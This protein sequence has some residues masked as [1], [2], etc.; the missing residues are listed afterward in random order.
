MRQNGEWGIG[1]DSQGICEGQMSVFTSPYM[2]YASGGRVFIC[3]RVSRGLYFSAFVMLGDSP[4]SGVW[5]LLLEEEEIF[6][7]DGKNTGTGRSAV[8]SGRGDARA[9]VSGGFDLPGHDPRI[10]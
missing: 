2:L 9:G 5:R 8:S 7:P 1:Y 6:L 4:Y 10:Q 3:Y